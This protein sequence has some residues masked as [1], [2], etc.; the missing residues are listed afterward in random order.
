MNDLIYCWN[1]NANHI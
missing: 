1:C